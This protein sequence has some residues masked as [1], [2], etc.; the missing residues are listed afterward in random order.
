MTHVNCARVCIT[1]ED[2]TGRRAIGWG[3]TPLNVQWAWPGGDYA[4]RLDAMRK[5]CV[6]LASAWAKFNC[7]GHP[8][9]V[10]HAFLRDALPALVAQISPQMPLLAQLVCVSAFDI[11]CHDAFG[12]LH[13]TPVYATY[14]QDWLARDLSYYFDDRAFAGKYPAD[15]LARPERTLLAWHLVGALDA[16][17]PDDLSGNEVQDGYPNCLADWISRDGLRAIK[18]KLHGQDRA[19]DLNRLVRVGEIA[20]DVPFLS[21]DFN[22]T[23]ESTAY[24]TS[25]LDE[26]RDKHRPIFDRLLYIE[27]PFGYD[28]ENCD[29]DVRPIA[30]RKPILLD[31]SAHDWRMV[32]LGLSRG[33]TGV[34]LKTCKTQTNAILSLCWARANRMQIMVQDLTNPMLAIIPHSQL[35]AYAGTIAGVEVNA[36]QFYP[37][38]SRAEA[39]VHPGLYRRV[40]GKIDLR[41]LEGPGFGYGNATSV[42]ELPAPAGSR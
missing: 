14:S 40:D 31:E 5:L 17:T 9:E 25:V 13:A 29:I 41:T 4:H 22:C 20:R 19:W 21:A 35:A 23:A 8:M 36:C 7:F 28:L 3:E 39:K 42:R 27:Q 11:A 18:I 15:Y 30:E 1:V 6:K 2:R 26:L 38:A 34:A 12:Q 10:G 33:W 32:Q 16:V 24:V 37:E